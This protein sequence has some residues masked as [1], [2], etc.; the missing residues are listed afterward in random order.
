MEIIYQ[1][2]QLPVV[3]GRILEETKGKILCFYGEMGAGKTTLIKALVKVLG[4]R[5]NVTSPTFGIVNAYYFDNGTL[6]GY[7]FDFYRV[8]SISEALD[9][10]LEDYLYSDGWIFVEW[11]EKVRA[12]FTDPVRHLFIE[13]LD[14]ET[15]KIV[16]RDSAR[17]G[18]DRLINPAMGDIP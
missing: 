4:G 8:A 18:A 1:E 12:F 2:A 14:S 6:L 15:R 17:G 5:E 3:A 9:M 13:E 10:G 7:H 11:P 16:I